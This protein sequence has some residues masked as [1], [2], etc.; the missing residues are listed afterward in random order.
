[1]TKLQFDRVKCIEKWSHCSLDSESIR[2]KI[3]F[4]CKASRRK[5]HLRDGKP[6][7]LWNNKKFMPD[8]MTRAIYY[9]Q[10]GGKQPKHRTKR[11]FEFHH[12][13]IR[14]GGEKSC[15][16]GKGNRQE[17]QATTWLSCASCSPLIDTFFSSSAFFASKLV[18]PTFLSS[19]WYCV[20]C[21]YCCSFSSRWCVNIRGAPSSV[22]LLRSNFLTHPQLPLQRR[23]D[24]SQQSRS[25]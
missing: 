16:T 9:F 18:W 22:F 2:F 4:R 7:F 3:N 12:L 23:T 11:G 10:E 8:W 24:Q 1:M 15:V 17:V 13:E 19:W 5:T 21:Y 6:E 25:R 14:K 20:V